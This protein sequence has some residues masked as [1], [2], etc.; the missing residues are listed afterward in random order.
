[1]I[2]G[3]GGGGVLVLE[4]G[5]G[6]RAR[7][8]CGALQVGVARGRTSGRWVVWVLVG[9]CGCGGGGWRGFADVACIAAAAA[10][11]AADVVL[12]PHQRQ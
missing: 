2:R 6:E 5:V 10:A 9:D 7:R 4:V 12:V 11:A 3:G 8:G 1:M